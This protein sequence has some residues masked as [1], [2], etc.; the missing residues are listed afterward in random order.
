MWEGTGHMNEEELVPFQAVRAGV[1]DPADIRRFFEE[2][3]Y[4]FF[5]GVLDKDLVLKAKADAVAELQRQGIVEPD[6]SEP[7]VRPGL[8]HTHIDDGPIYALTSWRDITISPEL[9]EAID[10]AYGEPGYIAPTVGFRHAMPSDTPYVTPPHQDYFYIQQTDQFRMIWI[11]LMD[12]E[13]RQ[14]WPGDRCRIGET[15][16]HRACR[17]SRYLLGRLQG[18]GAERCAGYGHQWCLDFVANGGRRLSHV[19]QLCSSPGASKRLRQGKALAQYVD[20]SGPPSEDLAGREDDP[21]VA[22]PTEMT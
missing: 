14:R 7:V 19:A 4:L 10:I 17:A 21:R 8:T 6:T 9:Q 13:N 11:P 2:N 20:V 1:D 5:K 16:T 18:T 12:L 3:S 15:R 22:E